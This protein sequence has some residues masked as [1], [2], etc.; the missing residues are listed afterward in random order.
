M[1]AQLEEYWPEQVACISAV[2]LIRIQAKIFYL[3]E[4]FSKNST[5]RLSEGS[6]SPVMVKRRILSLCLNLSNQPALA[7]N[8]HLFVITE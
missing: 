6:F 5:A 8:S 2:D 1:I 3:S 7:F 4:T